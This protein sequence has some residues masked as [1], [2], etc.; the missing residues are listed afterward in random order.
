VIENKPTPI[1]ML[2]STLPEAT[3]EFK[4]FEC[5][6]TSEFMTKSLF[7]RNGKMQ[8]KLTCPVHGEAWVQL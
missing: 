4:C 2:T 6:I 8:Y 1:A 7:A 5:G 3:V